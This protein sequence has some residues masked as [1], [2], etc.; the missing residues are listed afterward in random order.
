MILQ[1]TCSAVELLD[2]DLAPR[3]LLYRL[4]HEEGVRVF[5]PRPLVE[6]C[7]CSRDRLMEVLKSLPRDDVMALRD[8]GKVIVTCEFCSQAYDFDA[9]ALASIWDPSP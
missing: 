4:F 2:P 8:D 3:D 5:Q 9:E 7:R 6:G 1:A